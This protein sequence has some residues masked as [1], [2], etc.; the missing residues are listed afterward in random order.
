M[1]DLTIR[2]R[3]SGPNSDPAGSAARALSLPLN[4]KFDALARKRDSL[5]VR[6]GNCRFCDHL[7]LSRYWAIFTDRSFPRSGWSGTI[8][9]NDG[10]RRLEDLDP[11]LQREPGCYP[12]PGQ[13]DKASSANGSASN[14]DRRNTSKLSHSAADHELLCSQP[15]SSGAVASASTVSQTSTLPPDRQAIDTGKTPATADSHTAPSLPKDRS[16]AAASTVV[17]P[18]PAPEINTLLLQG[19]AAFR[20]GDLAS[21]R[22]LYRRA[23]EAG[24]G[25]GALGIGASYDPFFL[26]RFHLWTQIA[27]PD[28]ARVWY[29][30]AGELGTSEA[31]LR[32]DR[33]GTRPSR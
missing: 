16:A 19:D 10:I 17:A 32:L 31:K 7:R 15:A 1:R 33:L 8:A 12:N 13:V 14:A 18:L 6:V 9:S 26:R 21:A 24:E 27:D 28:E 30:R 5:L 25:R 4:S 11:R 22:L 2:S 3:Y 23:F 20:R 29:L